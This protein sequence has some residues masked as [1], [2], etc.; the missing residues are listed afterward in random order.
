M[1]LIKGKELYRIETFD[2]LSQTHLN[3][4]MLLYQPVIGYKAISI[5]LTLNSEKKHLTAYESINRIL[6]LMNIDIDSFC[7]GLKKLEEMS[8]LKSFYNEESHKYVFSLFPPLT[9][10]QFLKHDIYSRL[11]IKVMN[12]KEYENTMKRF[13]K[14]QIDK[15]NFKDISSHFDTKQLAT[16]DESQEVQ[17]MK[18]HP[19]MN[20]AE[21]KQSNIRFDYEKFIAIT[22]GILFPYETRT[23]ENLKVIGEYATIYGLSAEVMRQIVGKCSD[24]FSN[25]FDVSKLR[26]LCKQV[27]PVESKEKNPYL[28]SCIS[29]LQS[30]LNG[31]QVPEYEKGL[32]EHLLQDMKLAPE[33]INVVV[34]YALEKSGNRLTKNFL[35]SIAA[36]LKRSN[37]QSYKEAIEYLNKDIKVRTTKKT[38]YDIPNYT[39]EEAEALTN[40]QLLELQKWLKE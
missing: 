10:E 35:D 25:Q 28:M 9:T 31:A 33:V 37:I 18:V 16:W 4:L 5:Y 15:T 34:E 20:F 23:Q 11:L 30:K 40:E 39:Q 1:H 17:F 29:F 8:L 27:K 21:E 6:T 32:L 12:Q 19:K 7:F 22:D 36:S 13:T 14:I 38:T 3:A 24:P 26:L 2:V